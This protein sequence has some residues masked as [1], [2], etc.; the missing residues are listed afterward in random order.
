MSV[1]GANATVAGLLRTQADGAA[2]PRS[3]SVGTSTS[4]PA[5]GL[6]PQYPGA[7]YSAAVAHSPSRRRPLTA[8]AS[9]SHPSA[10][11]RGSAPAL[12]RTASA[13]SAQLSHRTH[14]SSS[15][16]QASGFAAAGGGRPRGSAVPATAG[17]A[18]PGQ[19]SAVRDALAFVRRLETRLMASTAAQPAS[20]EAPSSNSASPDSRDLGEQLCRAYGRAG[21]A[22]APQAAGRLSIYTLPKGAS[23]GCTLLKRGSARCA[24]RLAGL[25]LLEAGSAAASRQ[26][27]DK[28][29]LLAQGALLHPWPGL[30][31]AMQVTT[32]YRLYPGFMLQT[33]C[34]SARLRHYDC[35]SLA[36]PRAAQARR[37][38]RCLQPHTQR[39]PA[40]LRRRSRAT[41][42]PAYAISSATQRRHRSTCAP[43]RRSRPPPRNTQT[44]P[45]VDPR[46]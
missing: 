27:L 18:Q 29:L 46:T 8:S 34:T 5:P 16:S 10:V 12:G 25:A 37:R 26:Q 42:W 28:G 6:P 20:S 19:S 14:G 21:T 36:L 22:G 15:G 45:G 2:S 3:T 23:R 4:A 7:P 40:L 32:C 9:V 38:G 31:A 11:S 24:G 39:R 13:S 44:A 43:R 17:P 30:R 35:A 41:I 33:H 1:A